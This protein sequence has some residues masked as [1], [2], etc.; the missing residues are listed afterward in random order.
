MAITLFLHLMIYLCISLPTN[1][2]ETTLQMLLGSFISCIQFFVCCYIITIWV[3]R[4]NDKYH[5]ERPSSTRSTTADN[6]EH[7]TTST[8]SRLSFFPASTAKPNTVEMMGNEK[9]IR[10]RKLF[11]LLKTKHGFNLFM[12]H[13]TTELSIENMLF[14][15]EYIQY[16]QALCKQHLGGKIDGWFEQLPNEF[17]PRAECVTKFPGDYL[18]QIHLLF[19]KY[20]VSGSPLELNISARRRRRILNQFDEEK[21]DGKVDEHLMDKG[22]KALSVFYD[23]VAREIWKLMNDSFSRLSETKEYEIWH[24]SLPK[25]D[26]KEEGG[27]EENRTLTIPT[28]A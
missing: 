21:Q 28:N 23:P 13:L 24:D 11:N 5:I 1:N 9:G 15:I 18:S 12:T 7:S 14:T 2:N 17:I 19:D 27:D 26:V 25:K 3:L 10:K 6:R 8:I 22:W 4:K 20:I 16:K